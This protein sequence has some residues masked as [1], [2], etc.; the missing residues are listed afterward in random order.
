MSQENQH[1]N[2]LLQLGD[3]SL[4]LAQRLGEWCGH[5]PILEQDIALSN[6][7]L[8]LLGQ[9][10]NLL[11]H[12]GQIEGH[13]RS[14]DDLAFLRNERQYRNVL[15][16]EQPNGH[17]GTTILRQFF[18]DTFQYYSQQALLKSADTHLAAIAEKAIKE[19]TYHLRFSSEWVI[20][21]GDGTEESHTRMRSALDD[22]WRFVGELYTPSLADVWA[23]ENGIGPDLEIIAQLWKAKV[24][25]VLTEATLPVPE[26]QA[27]LLGGKTG[28]HTEHLGHI[29]PEMQHLQRSY[30]GAEW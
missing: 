30:P 22:L 18:F 19:T 16:V 14:E 23:H 13:G 2:Y 6:I 29:L 15:L 8:D 3:N 26:D 25:E 12:A 4:I 27:W 28:F 24:H 1:L 9:T 10:R 11:T 20:R 7:A 17:W 5:G 21:L